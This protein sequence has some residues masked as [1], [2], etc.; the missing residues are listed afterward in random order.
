MSTIQARMDLGE[1]IRAQRTRLRLTM[2]CAVGLAMEA[3]G[4]PAAL[5]H[6][7]CTSH[8]YNMGTEWHQVM[9]FGPCGCECHSDP[10]AAS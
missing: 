10:K 8:V 4:L 2:A 3:R 6:D 9:Y 5:N 7:G 1:V